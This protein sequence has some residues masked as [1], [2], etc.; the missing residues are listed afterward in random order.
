MRTNQKREVLSRRTL[1]GNIQLTFTIFCTIIMDTLFRYKEYR[2]DWVNA[3]YKY[4]QFFSCE[5]L[6]LVVV[7]ANIYLTDFFLGG[8]FMK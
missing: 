3:I 8:K 5:I 1:L 7:V 2:S 4:M 6:N